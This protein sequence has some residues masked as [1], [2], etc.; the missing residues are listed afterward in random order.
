MN[1][2]VME[3]D[4]MAIRIPQVVVPNF[5]LSNIA[6]VE[7]YLETKLQRG[8][9]RIAGQTVQGRKLRVVEYEHL[10]KPKLM[11]IGGTHGHEPGTVASTMNLIHLL[12]TGQ[13]L[14]GQQHPNLLAALEQVHLLV[15]PMLNPDG[16]AVCPDSFYAQGL[17]TV[18]IYASG[19][20][21]NGDLVPYDADSNEPCYYFDPAEALFVGGQFNAA[22]WA[23]NRRRSSEHSDA[24]EVQ[25][26]LEF[27]QP[28]GLEAIMDLH[29]C[30]YNFAMQAR[31]LPAR[32]WPVIREWQARAE[33]LFAAKG[34]QLGPLYGDGNP[35][36][37]PDFFFNSILF[38]RQAKLGWMSYEGRQGYVGRAAFMPLPGE[39]EIIDDYLTAVTIFLR[40]GA[41]GLWTEANRETFGAR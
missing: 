36:K 8:R 7:S 14:A 33:P 22:G 9:L 30:G 21:L 29:A 4:G 41:E 11:V 20:K 39:W 13:D 31:S 12:E 32:Y 37:P 28:L 6:A 34:R 10:G 15:C 38:H 23:I 26:L 16:R 1:P 3:M 19:L 35:P 25:Q 27:V 40:L 2:P 5:W 18:T 24:I 17:D